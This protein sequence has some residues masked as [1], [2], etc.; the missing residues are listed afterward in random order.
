MFRFS[1]VTT[2]RI[3]LNFNSER[4]LLASE[5]IPCNPKVR[6]C[7]FKKLPENRQHQDSI[8]L[9]LQSVSR[10]FSS[11]LLPSGFPSKYLYI[12]LSFWCVLHNQQ[13]LW[14]CNLKFTFSVFIPWFHN[15]HVYEVTDIHSKCRLH[16]R[17]AT[18]DLWFDGMEEK[19]LWNVLGRIIAK[20][21]WKRWSLQKTECVHCGWDT[22]ALLLYLQH[23][24]A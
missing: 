18:Q 11:D 6:Y 13:Y 8:N 2:I 14:E 19:D 24:C 22:T 5:C 12:F 15:C 10:Y 16:W 23:F 17:R 7:I 20:L 21:I 4:I 3:T 9:I 1:N